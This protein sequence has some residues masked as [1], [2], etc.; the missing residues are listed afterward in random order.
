MGR[1]LYLSSHAAV[2]QAT[3]TPVFPV[4]TGIQEVQRA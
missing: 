4:K 3:T 1:S 2:D